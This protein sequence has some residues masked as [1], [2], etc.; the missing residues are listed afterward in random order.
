MS[1]DFVFD[2][3]KQ[4]YYTEDDTPNPLNHYAKTK[5]TLNLL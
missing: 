4:G 2:G 5:Y 1:T 3:K